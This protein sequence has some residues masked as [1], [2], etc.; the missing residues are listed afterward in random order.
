MITLTP[1]MKK[2]IVHWGEMGTTWGINRTVAQIHA[3][4]YIS[5][6]PLSADEI[7][8]IL[9][10]ARSNVSNSLHELL[11]WRIVK[12]SHVFGDRKD[13]YESMKDVCEMFK[14]VLDERKKREIDP[15]LKILQECI[16]EME[17]EKPQN[18]YA[19]KQVQEFLNFFESMTAWYE[20]L[21]VLPIE[22]ILGFFN[23]KKKV[24]K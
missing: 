2:F 7:A 16:A 3:L 12:V 19:R 15:T 8:D 11:N 18:A 17:A 6:E 21:K 22:K 20:K 23:L 14:I 13:H 4:L 1:A 10:V 9:M 5:P 24:S